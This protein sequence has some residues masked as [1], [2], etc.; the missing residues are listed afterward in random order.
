MAQMLKN[1]SLYRERL[2]LKSKM[3]YNKL[4]SPALAAWDFVAISDSFGDCYE[5]ETIFPVVV[6]ADGILLYRMYGSTEARRTS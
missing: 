5:K 1:V 4:T 2:V 6:R 3:C